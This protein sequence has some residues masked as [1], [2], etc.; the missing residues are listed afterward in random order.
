MKKILIITTVFLFIL[1]GCKDQTET[2]KE[3]DPIITEKDIIKAAFDNMPVSGYD[4]KDYNGLYSTSNQEYLTEQATQLLSKTLYEYEKRNNTE[5]DDIKTEQLIELSKLY[6]GID[7]EIT[8]SL[9]EYLDN[10]AVTEEVT[11]HN[12]NSVLLYTKD[13][14]IYNALISPGNFCPIIYYEFVFDGDFININDK[15]YMNHMS[16]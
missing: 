4:Y 16:L 13:G 9:Y 2:I 11:L 8:S 7:E 12:N 6:F 14:D 3:E 1:S 10:F 15:Q 5:L